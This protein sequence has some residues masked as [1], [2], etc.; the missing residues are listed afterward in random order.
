ME[1]HGHSYQVPILSRAERD[2]RWG[3][4]RAEMR[5]AGLDC[6]LANSGTGSLGGQYLTHIDMDGLAIFPLERE[7]VFLLPS[8]DRW[9]HW[10]LGSQDWVGD[11]RPVRG[12]AGSVGGVLE[13]LKA[14]RVGLVDFKGM[15]AATYAD[16]MNEVSD[17]ETEDASR[18]VDRARL[19]K[20][21]EEMAMMQRAAEVGDEAIAALRAVARPGVRENEVYAEMT[22]VLL[23]GGCEPSSGLSLEASPRPFHPVRRPSTRQLEEGDVVMA[24]I[25]PRY[26]GYFGHPHVCLTIGEPR[27][28][29][30]DMFRVCEEAF[31]TFKASA[32]AGASLADVCRKTLGVI[33]NGGYDWRKEPVCH[34]IGLMQ[35]EPPVGGVLPNPYPDFELVENNTLGLHPWVGHMAAGNGIDSGR[36]VRITKNGAVP[37]GATQSVELLTV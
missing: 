23:S 8:G 18:V 31:E 24:H 1:P 16:V 10:A 3:R 33:E 15:H 13:E 17:C 27:P 36:S 32:K 9:H 14:R 37:F 19:V 12:L 30:S 5:E 2:Q 7:P 6:L 25:N 29:I 4:V 28:E 21:E 11:V 20:S 22:R 34:S 26:G 35:Q